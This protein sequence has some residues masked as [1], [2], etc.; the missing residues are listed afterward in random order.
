M[1]PH[2]SGLERA[3]DK[4]PKPKIIYR[5]VAISEKKLDFILMLSLDVFFTL[6]QSLTKYVQELGNNSLRPAAMIRRL[7][8]KQK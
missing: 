4:I 6:N 3:F 7:L 2:I 1:N 8:V 5:E